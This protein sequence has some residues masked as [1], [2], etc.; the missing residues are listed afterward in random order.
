EFEFTFNVGFSNVSPV[1]IFINYCKSRSLVISINSVNSISR[2]Q[3]TTSC[4]RWSHKSEMTWSLLRISIF[5]VHLKK[6]LFVISPK[7]TYI[8]V[9]IMGM[10]EEV[11]CNSVLESVD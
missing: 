3:V 5:I 8:E 7:V 10:P 6:K 1:V 4:Q 9:I 2:V 11:G